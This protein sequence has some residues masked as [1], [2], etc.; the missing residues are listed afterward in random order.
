M[1]IVFHPHSALMASCGKDGYVRVWRVNWLRQKLSN[2]ARAERTDVSDPVSFHESANLLVQAIRSADDLPVLA[3]D[4]SDDGRYLA[5]GTAGGM[6]MIG[7]T[8]NEKSW[9]ILGSHDD[10]VLS[11][12]VPSSAE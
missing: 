5:A 10:G 6:V 4:V 3:L 2:R 12:I 9:R 11:L 8:K 1:K 7:E